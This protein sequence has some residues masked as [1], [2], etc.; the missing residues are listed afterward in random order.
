[1]KIGLLGDKIAQIPGRG[2][3][4]MDPKINIGLD[5]AALTGVW[6]KGDYVADRMVPSGMLL[7]VEKS[8][9]VSRPIGERTPSTAASDC[10]SIRHIFGEQASRL[11]V[12]SEYLN[13][14]SP[15]GLEGGGDHRHM[16]SIR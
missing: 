15:F 16:R 13:A 10:N 1:M 12:N 7:N 5:K 3:R 9:S 14:P 8:A 11:A 4:E 6:L 2:R